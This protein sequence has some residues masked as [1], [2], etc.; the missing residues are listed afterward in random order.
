MK[1]ETVVANLEIMTLHLPE[2][3]EETSHPQMSGKP[4]SN[5]V[6]ADLKQKSAKHLHI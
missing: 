3:Q 1:E 2:G 4:S 6:K 5:K